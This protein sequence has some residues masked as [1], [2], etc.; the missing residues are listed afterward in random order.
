MRYV[1]WHAKLYILPLLNIAC[2]IESAC[3]NN[4]YG[5]VKWTTKNIK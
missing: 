1:F 5:D 4:D 3:K 2:E